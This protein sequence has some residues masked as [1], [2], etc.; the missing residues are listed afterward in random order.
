MA[1]RT[2]KVTL[3]TVTPL[4]LGGAD[5]RTPELRPPP[6]RGMMRYWFRALAGGVVGDDGQA[7]KT[8]R[9]K[10]A[11]IFGSPDEKCGLSAVWVRLS[12]PDYSRGCTAR[13]LPHRGDTWTNHRG[14]T[15]RNRPQ[16]AIPP[17]VTPTLTLTLKPGAEM[18]KLKMAVWSLLVGLTLGGVGKRSRR[19]LGSLQ[20]AEMGELPPELSGSLQQ[21]LEQ[22]TKLSTGGEDLARYIGGLLTAARSAFTTFL[23]N[24]IAPISDPPRFSLL[25]P[26]TH[27]VVWTP[28]N[29]S[30]TDYQTTLSALM[31]KLS[32]LTRDHGKGNFAQAFGGIGPR[33]ASPLWVSTHRLQN[34]GWAL[35][36]THLKAQYLSN[37]AGNQHHLVTA[38]LD[39]PPGGWI[40][41][42]VE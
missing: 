42:E 18:Q 33:R 15:L 21:Q 24:P 11:E 13:V 4:F 41:T 10:E 6:F 5:G 39:S 2:I 3:E 12:T 35:V 28:S 34:D 40:K 36:L 1:P 14:Q 19:G 9:Q 29:N 20:V 25:G 37:L 7:L 30:G 31:N 16:P 23:G 8:I 32:D 38:F 17:G 27:I 22:A 26:D